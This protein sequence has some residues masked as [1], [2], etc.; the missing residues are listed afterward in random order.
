MTYRWTI[1]EGAPRAEIKAALLAVLCVEAALP[2]GGTVSAHLAG[3]HWRIS[4]DGPLIR[5]DPAAF[6]V[7]TE[8]AEGAAITPAGIQFLLLPPAARSINRAVR[9]ART[10]E[11][12][13][14]ISF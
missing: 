2:R 3:G 7:L 12:T 8:D 5:M 10:G 9:V 14:M 11:T 1:N 4:G 13:L 6:A